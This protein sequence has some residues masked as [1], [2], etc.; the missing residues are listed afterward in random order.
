MGLAPHKGCFG[1][2][3]NP[4]PNKWLNRTREEKKSL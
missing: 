2:T 3:P 1:E 4:G